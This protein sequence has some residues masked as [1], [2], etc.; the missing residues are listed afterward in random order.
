MSLLPTAFATP[1]QPFYAPYTEVTQGASTLVTENAFAQNTTQ[2]TVNYGN[3]G[4][5]PVAIP[6]ILPAREDPFWQPGKFYRLTWCGYQ[7]NTNANPNAVIIYQIYVRKG[8]EQPI[9]QGVYYLN[10]PTVFKTPAVAVGDAVDTTWS[11]VIP[12]PPAGGLDNGFGGFDVYVYTNDPSVGGT[13]VTKHFS[14]E[15]IAD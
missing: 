13:S 15:K 14:I 7:Y 12:A 10:K 2:T 9:S 11:I 1:T 3:Q 5:S 6:T 4:A 8:P